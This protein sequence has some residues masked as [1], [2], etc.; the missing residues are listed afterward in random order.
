[1]SSLARKLGISIQSVSDSVT[2]GQRIAEVK[3]DITC[4]VYE[5]IFSSFYAIELCK[6]IIVAQQQ[7]FSAEQGWHMAHE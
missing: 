3:A 5:L 6:P 4:N 1:M 2:R 7:T